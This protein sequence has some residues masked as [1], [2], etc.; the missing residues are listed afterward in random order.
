MCVAA[1]WGQEESGGEQGWGSPTVSTALNR[2]HFHSTHPQVPRAGRVAAVMEEL[3]LRYLICI[4]LS[5]NT[6]RC[7]DMILTDLK[8]LCLA[9][10]CSF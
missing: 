3:I 5:L 10:C 9:V 8:C 2:G 4:N 7:Q 1:G 6:R